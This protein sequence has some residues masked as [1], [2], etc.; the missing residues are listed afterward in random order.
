MMKLTDL[1]C[2]KENNPRSFKFQMRTNSQSYP[3]GTMIGTGAYRLGWMGTHVHVITF[4]IKLT[5]ENQVY[6]RY[7]S[8]GS[9]LFSIGVNLIDGQWHSIVVTYNETGSLSLYIDN[10]LVETATGIDLGPFSND[11]YGNENWLGGAHVYGDVV[12]SFF[13]GDLKEIAFYDYAL[14]ASQATTD[15]ITE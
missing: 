9:Y 14:T 12:N 3:D 8:T 5:S 2:V 7:G 4:S 11:T 6:V 10:A 15:S 13:A 1:V